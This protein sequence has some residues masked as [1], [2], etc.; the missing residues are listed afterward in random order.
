L[1][2]PLPTKESPPF[3]NLC[4]ALD[5]PAGRRGGGGP[6]AFGVDP[7]KASGRFCQECVGLFPGPAVLS[8]GPAGMPSPRRSDDPP[9]TA[10]RPA[11]E[12]P[13]AVPA[14]PGRR[15]LRSP[16]D[17]SASN[18]H[19]LIELFRPGP[20][21]HPPAPTNAWPPAM[22]GLTGIRVAGARAA[23]RGPAPGLAAY[24]PAMVVARGAINAGCCFCPGPAMSE[25]V[26]SVPRLPDDECRTPPSTGP[27]RKIPHDRRAR[28]SARPGPVSVL[29]ACA[30]SRV[31]GGVGG[32]GARQPE[33]PEFNP[34]R[35]RGEPA[36]DV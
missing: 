28:S 22:G 16:P 8:A 3:S 9:A 12:Q 7:R 10:Q 20:P 4:R 23:S 2:T 26:G 34:R 21:R 1:V 14:N 29:P 30:S 33:G 25:F 13:R 24:Y 17:S 6:G 19:E 15:P 18:I 27:P 36:I 11:C 32:G 31:G 35:P 5:A